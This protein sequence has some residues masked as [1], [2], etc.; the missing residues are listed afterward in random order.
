MSDYKDK[1]VVIIGAANGIGKEL[2]SQF[3]AKGAKLALADIDAAN[4][5]KLEKDLKTK[6][7]EVLTSIFDVTSYADMENFAKKTFDKYG[8][9]DYLFNNAGVIAA[10]TIWDLPLKDWDWLFGVNVM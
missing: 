1:V 6:G 3:A 9:V 4:L 10:G 8:T 2:A 5:A 7:A